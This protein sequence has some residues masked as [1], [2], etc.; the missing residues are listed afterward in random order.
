MIR[1]VWMIVWKEFLQIGRDPRMLG[2]TVILPIFMVVLYGYAINLDVRHLKLAILDEDRTGASR[3]LLAA[4]TH[5]EYFLPVRDLSHRR[6]IEPILLSGEAKVVIVI[7]RGYAESLAANQATDIQLLIDGTDS[8]S[9][10][11]GIGYVNAIIREQSARLT[12]AAVRRVGS[13]RPDGVVPIENRFRN[14]YNPELRSANFIIP[15]LIAVILMMLSALLT[16]VTV[17]RERERGTIE[18]LIVSPLTAFE[19]MVGKL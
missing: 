18:Q 11:T 1:R 19:L 12:L 16:S 9:A 4:M 6:E 8:T 2:V 7:P 5:N 15:G 3:E 13:I 10:N 17:V 14:W